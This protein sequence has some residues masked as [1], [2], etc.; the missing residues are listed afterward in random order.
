MSSNE[1]QQGQQPYF[2]PPPPGPPPAQASHSQIP[3]H[4]NETPL[5][6][7][8]IPTYDPANPQFAPPPTAGDNLYDA[9]PTGERPPAFPGSSGKQD[10]GGEQGGKKKAN[11]LSG[12]GA[13]FASKVAGPVNAL[14]NKFGSEGFLPESLDKECEKAARILRSFCS[15]PTLPRSTPVSSYQKPRV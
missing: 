2:P 3:Q 13:A 5:P 8:T 4:P 9:S 14:V 1:K 15:K 10:S 11:R 12:F 7:Y 6:D